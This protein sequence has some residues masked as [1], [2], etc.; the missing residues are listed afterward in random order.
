MFLVLLLDSEA[1][2]SMRPG[3]HL[4]ILSRS[5]V[6]A[7]DLEFSECSFIKNEG[8]KLMTGDLTE[9]QTNVCR[10]FMRTLT[11]G[12]MGVDVLFLCLLQ[13]TTTRPLPSVESKLESGERIWE[14]QGPKESQG[15]DLLGLGFLSSFCF[16]LPHLS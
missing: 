9:N 6:P 7:L 11:S 13:I 2:S 4:H 16:V 15:G 8:T 10:K 5:L 3:L 14:P 12:K 1:I